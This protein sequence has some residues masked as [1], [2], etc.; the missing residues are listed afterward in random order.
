MI[1][2]LVEEG[3]LFLLPFAVFALYLVARRR[4]PFDWDHW[5]DRTAWLVIAG[6]GIAVGSL[7]YAGI[8]SERR[9][10][11]YRPPHLENGQLVPGAF[12]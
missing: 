12:R 7:L 8:A 1:R 6:L 10:D 3:L 4:N 9:N 11:G 5:T 2:A